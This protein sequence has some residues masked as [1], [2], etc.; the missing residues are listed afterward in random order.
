[1]CTRSK[2]CQKFGEKLFYTLN[3]IDINFCRFFLLIKRFIILKIDHIFKGIF[4]FMDSF[5]HIIGSK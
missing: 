4:Y 2:K 5:I 1:M 3:S